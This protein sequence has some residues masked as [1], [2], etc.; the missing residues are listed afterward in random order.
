MLTST[1]TKIMVGIMVKKKMNVL[2]GPK[3]LLST[4]EFTIGPKTKAAPSFE[5]SS[6]FVMAAP[7][8]WK[9]CWPTLVFRMNTARP[10]CRASPV[11]TRR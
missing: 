10:N 7:R 11:P 2:V 4:A 9:M 6:T 1:A 5:K 3:A 8:N